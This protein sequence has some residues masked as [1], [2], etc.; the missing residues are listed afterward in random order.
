MLG[1]SGDAQAVLAAIRAGASDFLDRNSDGDQLRG[2]LQRHLTAAA[3]R[4]P[5][6]SGQLTSII[7]A[8]PGSGEGLFAANLAALR[9]LRNRDTLLVDCSLPASDAAAALNLDCHY[10]LGSAFHDLRRLDRMLLNSALARHGGSGL[11]V[12]PLSLPGEDLAGLTADR[13][14][15]V[16]SVLRGLFKEIVLLVSGLSYEALLFQAIDAASRCFLVTTQKFT[17]VKD[18]NELLRGLQI[19]GET[20]QRITLAID[21]YHGEI[22]LDEAQM[23]SALGLRRAVRLPPAR[24]EL[25]NA[26]NVGEPLALSRPRS[27]YGR[28]L[29]RLAAYGATE[30]ARP[31]ASERGKARGG[32]LGRLLPGQS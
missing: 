27:P 6:D 5:R 29:K 7:A 12:L 14:L 23:L 20:L 24:V 13:V 9:A 19:D 16:L 4:A 28:A 32:L 10:T 15:S 31:A 18:C 11:Q 2:E 17:A 26:L 25:I 8:Q 3:S 22:T 1:D 30:P 21:D